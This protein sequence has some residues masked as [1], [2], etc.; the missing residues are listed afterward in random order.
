MKVRCVSHRGTKP[1]RKWFARSLWRSASLR[2]PIASR[3]A[4]VV[5]ASPV[6]PSPAIWNSEQEDSHPFYEKLERSSRSLLWDTAGISIIYFYYA[7]RSG[8]D[9]Q[10]VLNLQTRCLFLSTGRPSP[11]HAATSTSV[12]PGC[13]SECNGGHTRFQA[14]YVTQPRDMS[15]PYFTAISCLHS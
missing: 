7:A 2:V 13:K 14:F 6:W 12:S 10:I 5:P 8:C 11:E 1:V 4:C 3:G 15:F 9:A